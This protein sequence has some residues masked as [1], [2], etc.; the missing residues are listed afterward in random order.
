MTLIGGESCVRVRVK[1]EGLICWLGRIEIAPPFAG[2]RRF[3]EGCGFNQWTGDDSKALMKVRAMLPGEYLR[4]QK[5]LGLYSHDTRSSAIWSCAHGS[6]FVRF[7]LYHSMISSDRGWRVTTQGCP[8][9]FPSVLWNFH[10]D[11]CTRWFPKTTCT[12]SFPFIDTPF[13]SAKWTLFLNHGVQTYLSSQGALAMVKQK[14]STQPDACHKPTNWP[15]DGSTKWLHKLGN[16]WW[17]SV[18][19]G[20]H[21]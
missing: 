15:A 14:P 16:A 12:C 11:G 13:W 6:G 19:R 3:P 21:S 2:L 10:H 17:T 8:F 4:S 5:S 20:D 9:P 7:L 18:E 1:S